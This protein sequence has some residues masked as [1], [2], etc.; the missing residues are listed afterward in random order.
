MKNRSVSTWRHDGELSLF[1]WWKTMTK[2][3]YYYHHHH[4]HCYYTDTHTHYRGK[5]GGG[6]CSLT[7][8]N[9]RI[10]THANNAY[11]SGCVCVCVSRRMFSRRICVVYTFLSLSLADTHLQNHTPIAKNKRKLSLSLPLYPFHLPSK[12]LQKN[13]CVVCVR[14]FFCSPWL[15]TKKLYPVFIEFHLLSH[16]ALWAMMMDYAIKLRKRSS[17]WLSMPMCVC[18]CM[19]PTHLPTSWKLFNWCLTNKTKKKN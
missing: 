8:S 2:L 19:F 11:S 18:V 13:K 17:S 4:H 16:I 5:E 15:S 10:N 14:G 3:F 6:G 1:C 12:L 7:H 9:A